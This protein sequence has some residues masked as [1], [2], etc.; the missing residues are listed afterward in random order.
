[1]NGI[2]VQL[3]NGAM[4]NNLDHLN[5]LRKIQY[6]SKSTQRELASELGFSVG[7]LNYCLKALRVN[8]LIK[9]NNFKNNNKKISY[10]YNLTPKGLTK[11]TELAL[12]FMKE[13][14]REYD[15]LSKE[16]NKK[17]EI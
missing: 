10:I 17:V 11:K 7:K 14:M 13:N 9:I 8:G 5:L 6:K 15:Q 4:N 2:N 12:N 16:L 1:M 3:L